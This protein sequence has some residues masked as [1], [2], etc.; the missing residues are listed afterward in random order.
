MLVNKLIV[1]MCGFKNLPENN[2]SV[3][4][5]Y[6][7]IPSQQKRGFATHAV[8]LLTKEAFTIL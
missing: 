6:G 5:G 8:E 4:I 7:I 2:G 1:G 3:E